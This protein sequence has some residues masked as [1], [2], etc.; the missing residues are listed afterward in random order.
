MILI[1]LAL[2]LC[3]ARA[4][5]VSARSMNS[6]WNGYGAIPSVQ[7][8]SADAPMVYRV[9]VPWLIGKPTMAKYQTLQVTFITAALYSVY[10]AWAFLLRV[11]Q[12]TA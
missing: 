5:F 1:C 10:L 3:L 8:K 9:L 6:R 12:R 7:D 2:A 4:Q 11:T